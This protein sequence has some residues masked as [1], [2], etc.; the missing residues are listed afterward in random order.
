VV[1]ITR[2]WA[3]KHNYGPYYY[4]GWYDSGKIR[5]K[6]LGKLDDLPADNLKMLEEIRAKHEDKV[7]MVDQIIRI[8]KE[9]GEKK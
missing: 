3:K 5:W 6:Y 1:F 2:R 8:I 4:L 9:T 7:R